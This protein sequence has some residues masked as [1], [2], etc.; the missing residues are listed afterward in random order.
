[1]KC[2]NG[3]IQPDNFEYE[4]EKFLKLHFP[5][6][7]FETPE[8]MKVAAEKWLDGLRPEQFESPKTPEAEA[9]LGVL[10][11]RFL[12]FIR[13]LDGNHAVLEPGAVVVHVSQAVDF[14]TKLLIWIGRNYEQLDGVDR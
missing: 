13:L 3:K 12:E 8:S 11:S 10:K 5:E 14:Y 1:M 9:L 4:Y 6:I 2:G 7:G